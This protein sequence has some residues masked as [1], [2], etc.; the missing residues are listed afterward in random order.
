MTNLL[1]VESERMTYHDLSCLLEIAGN[2]VQV[3]RDAVKLFFFFGF[4]LL[5]D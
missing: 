1:L 2:N 3:I 4:F 5:S